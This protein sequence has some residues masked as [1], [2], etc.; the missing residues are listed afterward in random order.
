[1]EIRNLKNEEEFYS[2][3]DYDLFKK[4]KIEDEI[5]YYKNI[6]DKNRINCNELYLEIE[7]LKEKINKI[8]KE[9][10]NNNYKDNYI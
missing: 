9:N 1:M 5:F 4:K 10:N 3:K 8:T 7:N 2:I 6:T